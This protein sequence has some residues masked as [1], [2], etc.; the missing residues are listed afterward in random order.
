[1][2]STSSKKIGRKRRKHENGKT[3]RTHNRPRSAVVARV[4][5]KAFL[6]PA[7]IRAKT[8]GKTSRNDVS[9]LGVPATDSSVARKP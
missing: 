6:T 8:P 9:F 7:L 5:G 2:E 1:M 4:L 3:V